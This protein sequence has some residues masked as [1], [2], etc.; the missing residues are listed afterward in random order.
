VTGDL[1]STTSDTALAIGVLELV[2]AVRE[3][4]V[5]EERDFLGEFLLRDSL[6]QPDA[7]GG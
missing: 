3:D 5:A 6:V 1:C 7:F 2:R 4:I